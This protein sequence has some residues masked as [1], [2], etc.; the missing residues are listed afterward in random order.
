MKAYICDQCQTREQPQAG[1]ADIPPKG[2]FTITNYDQQPY[3]RHVCSPI[4]LLVYAQMVQ[5]Q[6]AGSAGP[7]TSL[8]DMHGDS[9]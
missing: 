8:P 4:C 2:W 3:N 9:L 5:P 7:L 1:G 6:T